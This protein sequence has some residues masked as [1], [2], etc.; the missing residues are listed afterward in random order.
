MDKIG[1]RK[2]LFSERLFQRGENLLFL[3]K[4]LLV[5]TPIQKALAFKVIFYIRLSMEPSVKYVGTV[6]K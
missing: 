3:V 5:I 4:R 1:I 6:V 2:S